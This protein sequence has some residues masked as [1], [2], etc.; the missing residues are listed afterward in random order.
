MTNLTS[1]ATTLLERVRNGNAWCVH[2]WVRACEVVDD[3]DEWCRR[4][5][6]F[7]QGTEKLYH[8]CLEL[9]EI[10]GYRECVYDEPKCRGTREITCWVCPSETPHWREKAL[11]RGGLPS[12]RPQYSG[13]SVQPHA[14]A[15]Y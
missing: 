12:P 5:D 13:P 6:L 7:W 11:G 8:L 3:R 4:T 1:S 2:A 9:E 15:H 14:S 10:E